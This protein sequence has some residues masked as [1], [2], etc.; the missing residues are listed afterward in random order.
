MNDYEVLIAEDD[1][2][3]ANIWQEF[4]AS[5]PGFHIAG[6]TRTGEEALQLMLQ[7]KIDLLIMDVYMP[8]LDGLQLLY[9]IR[10][11]SMPVDVVVI[12][13][14]KETEVILRML[15]MGVLDYIIKPCGFERF[16]LSLNHFKRFREKLGKAELEQKELD[17][18]LRPG[19]PGTGRDHRKLPKGL[20]DLTLK[21]ILNCFEQN[22]ISQSADEISKL[23]GLSPATVQ[24]YLKHLDRIDRIKK[25]LVYGSQGR[26]EHKYSK[27]EGTDAAL[28][29]I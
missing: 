27:K 16:Q 5:I 11:Q 10:K 17:Q 8:D 22:P 7:K 4:T 28:H 3:V 21:R 14:A 23:T 13:A 19:D 20:Q 2:R 29:E 12:T 15:R 25:E 24:R 26:P 18:I 9:E 1:F 6:E